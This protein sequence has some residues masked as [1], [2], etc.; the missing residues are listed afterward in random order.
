M[1]RIVLDIGDATN[2]LTLKAILEAEGHEIVA[3]RV[4]VAIAD[5]PRKAVQYAKETPSLVLATAA[6]IRA[7][8]D[9][10]RQGVYGY[11][12]VPFQPGEAGIM[13]QRAVGMRTAPAG[14]ALPGRLQ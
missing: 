4:D 12:F 7:A 3:E 6:D 9:A 10:M 1:A 8:V 14:Q 13:V 2:R 5:T 11:L